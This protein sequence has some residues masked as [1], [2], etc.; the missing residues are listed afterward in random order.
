M[1][2]YIQDTIV[3]KT[4]HIH[5]YVMLKSIIVVLI[6][7]L[8]LPN[9]ELWPGHCPCPTAAHPLETTRR[10]LFGPR[11]T[12][13]TRRC[14]LHR[15]PTPGGLEPFCTVPGPSWDHPC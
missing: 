15:M 4:L 12:A 9:R 2:N 11:S 3:F 14:R 13:P 1:S 6:L 8:R 10:W 7:Y 5:G